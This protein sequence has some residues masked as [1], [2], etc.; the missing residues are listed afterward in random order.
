MIRRAHIFLIFFILIW[1]DA[2]ANID[3]LRTLLLERNFVTV[4]KYVHALNNEKNTSAAYLTYNNLQDSTYS[5]TIQV[6]TWMTIDSIGI[7][8]VHRYHIS[9]IHN[10]DSIF[11]CKMLDNGI[12]H[13]KNNFEATIQ[14]EILLYINDIKIR[15]I[16]NKYYVNYSYEKKIHDLFNHR[17]IYGGCTRGG[18]N[19]DQIMI[20][21]VDI[22]DTNTLFTWLFS[23]NTELQ[24]YAVEGFYRLEKKGIKI[25]D[26]QWQI[27]S[28]IKNK[29]GCLKVCNGC[30]GGIYR[31]A[32]I[33]EACKKFKFKKRKKKRK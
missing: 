33:Q 6:Q 20:Y 7:S 22:I 9:L 24:V 27:I 10:P 13:I 1:V 30:I 15:E 32:E 14:N 17:I 29:T 2:V 11:Y 19:S 25:T 5:T 12:A 18:G 21:L 4:N 28:M 31:C 23:T 8:E 16:I 3:S 26:Q